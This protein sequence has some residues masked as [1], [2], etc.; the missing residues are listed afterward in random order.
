MTFTG[1]VTHLA[2]SLALVLLLICALHTE[3]I[4]LRPWKY[5]RIYRDEPSDLGGL[6]WAR[7]YIPR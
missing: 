6:L 7:S 4:G 5:D 1:R 2:T 3:A